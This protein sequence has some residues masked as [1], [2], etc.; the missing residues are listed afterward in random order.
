MFAVSSHVGR[1]RGN[2]REMVLQALCKSRQSRSRSI[3]L[4]RQ[5]SQYV[6]VLE[7]SLCTVN[8]FADAACN[9]L[10]HWII[11]CLTHI[12]LLIL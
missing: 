10:F 11:F 8:F 2:S 3:L 12:I 1:P 9:V 5:A 7:I 6:V 4:H